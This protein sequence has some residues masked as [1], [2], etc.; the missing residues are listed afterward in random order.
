M[1]DEPEQS[2]QAPAEPVAEGEDAALQATRW[3]QVG[4]GFGIGSAALVAALLYS[5]QKKPKGK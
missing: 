4:I 2:A 1:S 3:K 5:N